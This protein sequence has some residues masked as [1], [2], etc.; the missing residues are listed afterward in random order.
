MNLSEG[1]SQRRKKYKKQDRRP[2]VSR[3]PAREQTLKVAEHGIRGQHGRAAEYSFCRVSCYWLL[4]DPSTTPSLL[5][6]YRTPTRTP[7][8]SIP[9]PPPSLTCHGQGHTEQSSKVETVTLIE[10]ISWQ[11]RPWPIQVAHHD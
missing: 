6:A 4:R 8:S 1:V 3:V 10:A 2:D 9:L 7:T 11:P 5:A